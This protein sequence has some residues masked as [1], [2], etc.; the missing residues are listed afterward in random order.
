MMNEI[1]KLQQLMEAGWNIHIEC[2]GKGR[3]YEMS[4]EATATKVFVEMQD[5]EKS[6]YAYLDRFQPIHAVGN[7]MAELL[8]R[9]E[10]KMKV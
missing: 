7:T 4:F 10:R 3:S 5:L 8:L 1:E 9:L 2:K 6:P